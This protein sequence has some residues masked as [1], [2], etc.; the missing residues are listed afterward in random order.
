[1]IIITK[2]TSPT[3]ASVIEMGRQGENEAR[4]VWFDLTWL[5]ETY[6]EGTATV[7]HQRSKDDAPYLANVTQDSRTAVWRLTN[8][9]TAFDGY[10]KCELRWTVGDTLAKTITY[11]TVVLKSMAQDAEVPDAY[12]SWYDSMIEYIN[13]HAASPEQIAEA[14]EDYIEAHPITGAVDSVNGQ[15]GEVVLDAED[16]GALPDSTVIPTRTSD[17]TND[18]GYITGYTETDPTV[19]AWAKSAQKP[20]YTA[21]EV[22]ALPSDTAIPTKTSDLT[23]DSGFGTYTKP[24]GGI[25]KTDLASAV[26]TSLGK[27]DTALQTAPVSSVNSKTGAVVLDAGDLAY[28]DSAT[29]SSGTVGDEL[30]DLR[31]DLS[32][33]LDAPSTAGTSGQ[34]LGLD[35]N[36]VPAWINQSGGSGGTLE[37]I[38]KITTTEEVGE[39]VFTIPNSGTFSELYTWV[40]TVPSANVGSTRAIMLGINSSSAYNGWAKHGQVTTNQY[41]N[42]VGHFIFTSDGVLSRVLSS[43]SAGSANNAEGSNNVQYLNANYTPATEIKKLYLSCQNNTGVF[44]IG[45]EFFVWGVR[46]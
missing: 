44:G 37:Q 13:D 42:S 5:I 1:M 46:S 30:S 8:L 17:L 9:D 16:V 7:L 3:V 10:G 29:Y 24:S 15:T 28:S 11:K 21:Q 18:S 26:Q 12:Q 35:S 6:G 38:C 20:T 32:D 36:L 41:Q 25:P 4:E 27:A 19:P 39:I 22:G 43:S 34:V 33:K 23:N 40:H 14:V 2:I 31:G 45:T